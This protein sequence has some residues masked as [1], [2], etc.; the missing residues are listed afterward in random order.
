MSLTLHDVEYRRIWATK[1]ADY[2]KRATVAGS[3]SYLWWHWSFAMR[4]AAMHVRCLRR[5]G[6]KV[7]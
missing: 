7:I 5:Y 4:C 3:D 2:H 6:I 1:A